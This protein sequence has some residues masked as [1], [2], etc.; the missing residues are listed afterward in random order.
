MKSKND[1]EKD[2]FRLIN[3][4]VLEKTLEIVRRHSNI[5]LLTTQKRKSYL[6]C[7]PNYHTTKWFSEIYRKLNKTK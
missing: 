7:E 3:K 4:V 2:L 6:V 1:F 5:K